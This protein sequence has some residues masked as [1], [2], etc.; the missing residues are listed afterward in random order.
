MHIY[1]NTHIHIQETIITVE[2]FMMLG[3]TEGA[4]GKRGTLMMEM[5]Y[6]QDEIL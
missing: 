2:E 3:D 4:G 1:I 5:C 6:T